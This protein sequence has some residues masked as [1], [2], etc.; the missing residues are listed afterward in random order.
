MSLTQ[1]KKDILKY[2]IE[3]FI[4]NAEPV[5]SQTI[6]ES[7]NLGISPATIRKEMNELEEL[8]YLTHPH[9]SAGRIP[10]DLGYR[11]YVDNIV[12]GEGGFKLNKQNQLVSIEIPS[13]KEMD[14]ELI[15]QSA[16]NILFK[17]TNYVSMIITPEIQKSQFKHMELIEKKD[18]FYNVGI[19]I[20]LD[21]QI[22]DPEK[23]I[24]ISL[25][26]KNGDS[27]SKEEVLREFIL[28]VKENQKKILEDADFSLKKWSS[29]LIK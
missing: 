28:K 27:I 24:S 4:E 9:I 25:I 22:S 10:T 23:E 18:S 16:V 11:Y 17:F 15:L 26:L 13:N 14:L 19:G 5:S 20:N 2:L 21:N 12:F 6:A 1:R 7:S 8:G 29:Y 3:N